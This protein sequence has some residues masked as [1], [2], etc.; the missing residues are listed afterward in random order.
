M[1]IAKLQTVTLFRPIRSKQCH[2]LQFC[3]CFVYGKLLTSK[4]EETITVRTVGRFEAKL[5]KI[6]LAVR[7]LNNNK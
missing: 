7:L 5:K 3:I 6:G 4:R 2:C 1:H